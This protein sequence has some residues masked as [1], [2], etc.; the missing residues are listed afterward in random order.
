LLELFEIGNAMDFDKNSTALALMAT[1]SFCSGV[2]NKRYSGQQDL[3][4]NSSTAHNK[5]TQ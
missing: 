1:A 2:Q 5:N 4:T 3:A